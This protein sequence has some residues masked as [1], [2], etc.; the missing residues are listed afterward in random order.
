MGETRKLWKRFSRTGGIN[1]YHYERRA[2]VSSTVELGC[3]RIFAWSEMGT[4]KGS[5]IAKKSV[6]FASFCKEPQ[7]DILCE[8]EPN[9]KR[10]Q[11]L[12]AKTSLISWSTGTAFSKKV[13]SV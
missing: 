3:P 7:K 10:K 12:K 5:E 13:S 8:N 2:A 1:C 6:H 9:M 4:K 11:Y